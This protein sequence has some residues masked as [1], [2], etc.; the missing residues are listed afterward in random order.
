MKTIYSTFDARRAKLQEAFR[1]QVA[2]IRRTVFDGFDGTV[3]TAKELQALRQALN[4]RVESQVAECQKALSDE[5]KLLMSDY[6][7]K[8]FEQAGVPNA[9][10]NNKVFRYIEQTAGDEDNIEIRERSFVNL[11]EFV[12]TIVE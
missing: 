11:M 5:Y 12:K 2:D 4:D 10:I 3:G 1:E 7:E 9:T 6:K 8:L